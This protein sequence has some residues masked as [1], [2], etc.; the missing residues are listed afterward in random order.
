MKT[1]AQPIHLTRED[2]TEI[3]YA[4]RYKRDHSPAVEGDT[5]WQAHLDRIIETIGPDGDTA[6]DQGVEGKQ[7]RLRQTLASLGGA[8]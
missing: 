4:L 2:W 6:A 5:R 3:Y 1:K 7:A 8:Q